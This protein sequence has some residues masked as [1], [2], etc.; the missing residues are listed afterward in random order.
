[1][2]FCALYKKLTELG[3]AMNDQNR[4]NSHIDGFRGEVSKVLNKSE[5]DFLAW[6]NND[7]NA[8]TA[9]VWGKWDF[10]Y[11]I[12]QHL[13]MHIPDPHLC[14]ALEIGCGGGRLLS[15]SANY[16]GQVAGIDI[17]NELPRVN[18]QL[19]RRG[20]ANVELR[21]TDGRSIPFDDAEFDALYSF[22]VLQHVEHIDI[23]RDYFKE[24][25]RVLKPGGVGMCYVGRFHKFS[26]HRPVN[27]FRLALDML[28][29]HLVMPKGYRDKM[30]TNIGGTN[31]QVTLPYVKKLVADNGMEILMWNVSRKQVPHRTRE[32]GGQYGLL[33][34]KKV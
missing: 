5:D 19:G 1:M 8:E 27:Y 10:A 18:E 32:L 6:F 23:F 17:H 28:V 29:E 3:K 30:P 11:H 15:A 26:A 31:I 9:I 33:I 16:F 7:Q 24:I 13:A 12:A 20:I 22:V 4:Y 34:R 14:K 2:W 21:Q 25:A